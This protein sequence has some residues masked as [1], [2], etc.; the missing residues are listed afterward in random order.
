M[1]ALSVHFE[2]AV[3]VRVPRAKAYEAY[4]DFESMPKW[5]RDKREV[6]ASREGN[7]V[8]LK[9][10]SGEESR[11][12]SLFPPE[13]VESA[14]ETRITRIRSVVTFDEAPE[15][16]RVTASM[17]V[18]L[19]GRW[20]WIFK[21]RGRSEAESSAMEELNSFARYVEGLQ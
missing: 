21:T 4:T 3:F 16:T 10:A 6:K 15:G 19:K 1:Q 11:A 13:R 9:R 2:A 12:L 5:S 7:T 18:Q 14:G 8:H 20:S 17:D